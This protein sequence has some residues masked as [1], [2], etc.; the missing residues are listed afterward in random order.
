MQS[1]QEFIA[2]EVPALPN[3][4]DMHGREA[5]QID[6]LYNHYY[7]VNFFCAIFFSVTM[8]GPGIKCHLKANG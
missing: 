1:T 5:Q 6:I 8:S 3:E 7:M 4:R 2:I